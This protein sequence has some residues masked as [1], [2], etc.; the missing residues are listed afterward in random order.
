M[1]VLEGVE[2]VGLGEVRGVV[3]V[4]GLAL[5]PLLRTFFGDIGSIG[6]GDPDRSE[7]WKV[8]E[9]GRSGSCVSSKHIR[10]VIQT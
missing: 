3:K 5:D 7:L 2:Q 1:E 8:W 4:E 10:I 6:G 9:L